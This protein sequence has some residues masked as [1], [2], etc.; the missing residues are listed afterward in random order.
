MHVGRLAKNKRLDLAI[1]ALAIL[2]KRYPDIRLVLIG[3]GPELEPLKTL[4]R[5]KSLDD[6]VFFPGP[7]TDPKELAPWMSASD[8]IVAPGQIGLLAPM[9]LAYERTL[10]T[11]DCTEL[12]YPEV[13]SVIDKKSGLYYRYEDITDLADN[14][15]ALISNPAQRY[16]YAKFGRKYVEKNMGPESMIDAFL[17]AVHYAHNLH[18]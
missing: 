9:S 1:G 18:R 5:D 6:I 3:E 16:D 7:I 17:Q 13:Q 14:I 2:R 10:V 12:H 11:S 8:L 4:A 15:D